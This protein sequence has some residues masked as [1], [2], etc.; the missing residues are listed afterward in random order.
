MGQN[1]IGDFSYIEGGAE[2][3]GHPGCPLRNVIVKK[4]IVLVV[5]KKSFRM[6]IEFDI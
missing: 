5:D 3:Q 1:S 2:L 6:K 4:V